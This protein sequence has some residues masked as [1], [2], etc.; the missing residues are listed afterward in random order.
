MNVMDHSLD[1]PLSVR[2]L[3]T[4]L[5]L[6]LANCRVARVRLEVDSKY[7]PTGCRESAQRALEEASQI[8]ALLGFNYSEIDEMTAR[9]ERLKFEIRSFE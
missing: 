7:D 3:S 1:N 9:L 4:Q 8:S 5:S 2:L 6:G